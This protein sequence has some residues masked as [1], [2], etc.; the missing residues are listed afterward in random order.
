MR[1]YD[2][3]TPAERRRMAEGKP[4]S[5]TWEAWGEYTSVILPPDTTRKRPEGGTYNSGRDADS[6]QEADVSHE[7]DEGKVTPQQARENSK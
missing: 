4:A 6:C 5:N 3:Y 1:D 7:N 2:K